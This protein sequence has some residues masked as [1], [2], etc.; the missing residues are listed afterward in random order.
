MPAVQGQDPLSSFDPDAPASGEGIYGLPYTEE[1]AA[2]VLIPVPWEA[3]TSYGD[4]TAGG[5]EAILRASRQIDL[6]DRETGRPYETG[7]ACLRISDEVRRWNDE[8]KALAARVI[9]G[10]EDAGPDATPGEPRDEWTRSVSGERVGPRAGKPVARSGRL[11][12]LIG[13]DPPPSG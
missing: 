3:T 7:I 11:V 6:V 5:P 8:A 12:G 4:G 10:W 1:D 2:T 13:G 9:A